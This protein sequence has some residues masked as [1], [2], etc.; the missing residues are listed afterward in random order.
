MSFG[1]RIFLI[2][3]DLCFPFPFL[4]LR[5]YFLSFVVG[6][7]G[8]AI[9]PSHAPPSPEKSMELLE[10]LLERMSI[11]DAAFRFW[12]ELFRDSYLTVSYYCIFMLFTKY[13]MKKKFYVPSD[14][15]YAPSPETL[16]FIAGCPH[17][18]QRAI[19]GIPSFY[20]FCAFQ[21]I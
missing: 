15:S 18:V 17:M 9:C 7:E 6:E 10:K 8:P 14:I 4:F 19:I 1:K 13:D 2:V 3:C 11:S 21:S 5:A 20:T 12:Y 16:N